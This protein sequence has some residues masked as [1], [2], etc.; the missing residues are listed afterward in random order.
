MLWAMFVVN[1]IVLMLTFSMSVLTA[2]VKRTVH[3]E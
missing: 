2:S 1:Y 3:H